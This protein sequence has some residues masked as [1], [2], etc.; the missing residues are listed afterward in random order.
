M[1]SIQGEV[2]VTGSRAQLPG[3]DY[4]GPY[5]NSKP[6]NVLMC[7]EKSLDGLRACVHFGFRRSWWYGGAA[8]TE[9]AY[10]ARM[11]TSHTVKPK[12]VLH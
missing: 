4:T 8:L 3:H 6:R 12:Q 10:T 1:C 9:A 5:N 11:F 7:S 2:L